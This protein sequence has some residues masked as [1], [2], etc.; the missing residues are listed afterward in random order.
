MTRLMLG[1]L[2]PKNRV[3]MLLA[4][5]AF[6]S[7]LL[8]AQDLTYNQGGVIRGP[9]DGK[10]V[11]LV[12]TA[13]FYGEGGE[14][15]LAELNRKGIKASF[16]LT[17]NFLRR[18]EFRSLVEAMVSEGHYLGPHSDRHLLYCD[19]QDRQKTLVTR[20][21][22]LADL[23]ANY[24]E[25]AKFG[26]DRNRARYFMPPYE[27]YNQQIA[28]WAAEAGAVV[29][30]FTPGLIT[31]ADYTTPDM[32]G[33]R[34]SERIYRQ[35]L[36]YEASS[37]SGLNGFIILVHLGVAPD[38]TDPFYFRLGQLIDDLKDLGYSPVRIDELLCG[39]ESIS[40]P[41]NLGPATAQGMI[42]TEKERFQAR[43]SQPLPGQETHV[44]EAGGQVRPKKKS[45]SDESG[46]NSPEEIKPK[47]T[48][49]EFQ[50]FPLTRA[51][52]GWNWGRILGL[53]AAGDRL[54]AIFDSQGK[55]EGQPF[56]LASGQALNAWLLPLPGKVELLAAQNGF[57]LVADRKVY[58]IEAETGKAIESRLE[59][60]EAPLF[61]SLAEGG[62]LILLSRKKIEL[63][64]PETGALLWEHEL[65][66]EV[67]GPAAVSASEIVISLASG[68]IESFNLRT[69]RQ[70][71]RPGF[72]E[73]ITDLQVD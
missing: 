48:T 17:G 56:R 14:Y 21:E 39:E 58:F 69:G 43:P 70:I 5:L 1:R 9:V 32:P 61:I 67:N 11:A 63:R 8:L 73:G 4:L 71:S 55:L 37:A 16:F 52:V 60:T 31:N 33:Y 53:V 72:G 13:D 12:F 3:L 59:L 38:R 34:S 27:W 47:G 10:L 40:K 22:F 23:E 19:W 28:D 49:S 46:L 68:D 20:E 24:A 15:I 41:K 51:W 50:N 42:S 2:L 62:N 66:V 54:L 25:L 30:N 7:G 36:D 29:V 6:L 44:S 65:P 26:V 35:L 45:G 64:N 57:W 18:P